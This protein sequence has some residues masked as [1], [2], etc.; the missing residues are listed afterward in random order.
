[1]AVIASGVSV[2]LLATAAQQ[3]AVPAKD[4]WMRG[5]L[6]TLLVGAAGVAL[7]AILQQR[8]ERASWLR[9]TRLG[10][11]SDYLQ[12]CHELMNRGDA[13][14]MRLR[15]NPEDLTSDAERQR[16]QEICNSY[17]EFGYATARLSLVASPEVNG[18]ADRLVGELLDVFESIGG[19]DLQLDRARFQAAW[20]DASQSMFNLSVETLPAVLRR[21]MGVEPWSRIWRSF[22]SLVRHP[23]R[24]VRSRR[25]RREWENQVMG[26]RPW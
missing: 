22:A 5:A 10:A 2:G 7:G 20:P 26:R 9:S 16:F 1:M 8:R 18:A 23:V 24:Q 15:N 19:H 13:L 14:N 25:M 11:Y 21:E 3:A 12:Q 4:D 17:R 6:V